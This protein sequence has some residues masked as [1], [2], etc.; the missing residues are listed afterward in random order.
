MGDKDEDA[1]LWEIDNIAEKIGEAIISTYPNETEWETATNWGVANEAFALL[2]IL[3]ETIAHLETEK[4]RSDLI[5][6]V[7]KN[8]RSDVECVVVDTA[9]DRRRKSH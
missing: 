1:G 9:R 6:I 2:R 3:T 5:D 8:L 4:E 7:E